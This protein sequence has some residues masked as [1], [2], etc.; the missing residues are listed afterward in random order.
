M[1]GQLPE[2]EVNIT[3][4]V[5]NIFVLSKVTPNIADKERMTVV[6]ILIALP[7]PG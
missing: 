3:F 2:L 7:G 6:A 4:P 1:A 5:G